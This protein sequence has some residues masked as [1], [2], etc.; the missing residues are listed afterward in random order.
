MA[1]SLK[2]PEA[3]RLARD[4]AAL[5]GET[6]TRAVIVALR[7]RLTRLRHRGRRRRLRDEL[8]E[9]GQ[10]CARLPTLDDR[11]PDEIIGY[12]ESGLPG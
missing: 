8:R 7:E 5:T 10:R 3:D 4:L 1:L 6:L 12:D 2:D 11:S 9:I